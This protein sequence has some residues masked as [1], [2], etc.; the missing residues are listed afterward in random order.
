M[1][2]LLIFLLKNSDNEFYLIYKIDRINI[3]FSECKF[4]FQNIQNNYFLF[5]KMMK[6]SIF[7]DTSCLINREMI[8]LI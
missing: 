7:S 4:M 8:L 1:L 6:H 2:L 3:Y 5:Y